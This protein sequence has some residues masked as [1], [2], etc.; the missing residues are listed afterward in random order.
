[1]LHLY[2]TLYRPSDRHPT[3][4]A[5]I[6]VWALVADTEAEARHHA[7]GRER[8]R[9]DRQ[10]GVLGPLQRPEQIAA[11]GFTPAEQA[12][13]DAS[14]R[15]AL[16]GT[17]AHVGRQLRSLAAE[18]GLHELVVNT[19]AHDPAVRRHSYALLAGEFALTP[20]GRD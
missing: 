13:V 19:W 7:L 20:A 17:P 3:P 9:L 6:C 15:R 11:Q 14:S 5:T 12:L 10:R 16:V 4:Q 18:L 2:R 8:W 1:A